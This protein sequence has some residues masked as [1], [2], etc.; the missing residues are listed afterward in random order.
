M[1]CIHP[2]P[3]G[4]RVIKTVMDRQGGKEWVVSLYVDLKWEIS[5]TMERSQCD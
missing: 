1:K 2:I 5:G 3:A 4:T